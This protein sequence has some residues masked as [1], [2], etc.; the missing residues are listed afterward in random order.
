MSNPRTLA[1]AICSLALLYFVSNASAQTFTGSV[2]GRILDPHRAVI[3][4]AHVTLASV[5]RSFERHTTTNPEGEYT[6]P[7][8]PPGMF[9]LQAE[10]YGFTASG[11]TVEVVVATPVRADVVLH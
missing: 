2:V 10:S 7:L 4:N 1:T 11:V 9:T 3:G 8:V 5:D 6:F